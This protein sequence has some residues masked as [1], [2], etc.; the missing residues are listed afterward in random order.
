[1]FIYFKVSLRA[2][3]ANIPLWSTRIDYL[4]RFSSSSI[5]VARL[6]VSILLREDHLLILLLETSVFSRGLEVL[7][8]LGRVLRLSLVALDNLS[9]IISLLSDLMLLI[10]HFIQ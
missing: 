1:V 7:I 4:M 2:A 10:L 5:Q 9:V 6:L 3:I 8:I